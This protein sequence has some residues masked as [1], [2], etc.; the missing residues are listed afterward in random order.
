MMIPKEAKV[1]PH[2]RKRQGMGLFAKLAIGFFG[3]L[4]LG[5]VIGQ[6]KENPSVEQKKKEKS[7]ELLAK[8]KALQPQT[9]KLINKLMQPKSTAYLCLGPSGPLIESH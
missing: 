6:L 8:R 7:S 3:L 9:E 5:G 4:V 2:C 1:C